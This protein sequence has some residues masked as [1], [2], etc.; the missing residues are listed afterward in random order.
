MF[1]PISSCFASLFMSIC[2]GSPIYHIHTHRHMYKYVC[3]YTCIFIYIYMYIYI[4]KC[5]LYTHTAGERGVRS[6]KEIKYV[7]RFLEKWNKYGKT[8]QKNMFLY[9]WMIRVLGITL[10]GMIQSDL[11]ITPKWLF[12]GDLFFGFPTLIIY[13]Y[14]LASFRTYPIS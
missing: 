1:T 8:I 11:Q 9:N 5:T 7:V 13:I 4:C 2:K 3:R 6:R 14:K 12:N 10:F